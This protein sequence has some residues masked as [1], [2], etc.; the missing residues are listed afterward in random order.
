MAPTKTDA[1]IT[2]CKR[3]FENCLY[4]ATA[5]HI[6]LRFKRYVRVFFIVAPLVLGGLAGWAVLRDSPVVEIKYLTAAFSMLA[7]ILPSIF[8]ALRFDESVKELE[9]AAAT[10]GNLRDRFRQTAMVASRKPF[11]EFEAE[12]QRWMSAMEEARRQSITP[13]EWAFKRAQKK[14]QSGDYDFTVDLDA[15]TPAAD[16]PRAA[17]PRVEVQATHPKS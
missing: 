15:Q 16:D 7:G 9:L 5:L 6:W 4:T 13:P 12:F 11:A 3:Q 10:F 2:E 8:A 1:L 17:G 14:V